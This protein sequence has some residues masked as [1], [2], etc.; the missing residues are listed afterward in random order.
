MSQRE[1]GV[2]E[3]PKGVVNCASYV[4]GRRKADVAIDDI[5]EAI[6]DPECFLW[7]GLH[8]P[9]EELLRKVQVEFGLHDLAVEDAHRAHQRPKMD[10]YGDILFLALQTA[11]YKG[12]K[13][14]HGETHVFFGKR[15]LITVRHGASL[16]YEAVRARCEETPHLLSK[17]PAFALYAL[18]DF[19]VDQYF[20][21]VDGIGQAVEELEESV[22]S[23]KGIAAVTERIHALRRQILIAK[24]G[25]APVIDICNRLERVESEL[26]PEDTKPYF[27]D[28]F[29]HAFRI[30]EMLE[31]L[32]EVM[33][34]ALEASLALISIEQNQSMKRLSAWA[35]MVAVPTMIAGI[36]GMNFQHMPELAWQLGYPGSL[37]L[38]LGVCLGMHVYFRRTGWL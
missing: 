38:M 22:F 21:V 26:I 7:I 12:H 8:E 33:S 11:Q 27:R 28:V 13:V 5:S 9:S 20:P 18:L 23:G 10:R 30:N 37:L 17:G 3:H 35:A 29:D 2:I 15:F 34:S 14:L 1:G 36:Y 24:K 6:K 31:N 19:I 4:Q 25:T 16:P 32:R